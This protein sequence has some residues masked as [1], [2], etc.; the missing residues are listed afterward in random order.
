MRPRRKS[1][2]LSAVATLVRPEL[3]VYSNLHV[4]TNAGLL[5]EVSIDGA[6]ARFDANVDHHH[7]FVYDA[8][9]M[10][11]DIDGFDPPP[12]KY[13]VPDYQATFRVTCNRCGESKNGGLG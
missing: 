2:S 12:I 3:R 11:E 9:G 13:L 4:L 5:R 7:H 10:F 6:A 8:Y 1:L